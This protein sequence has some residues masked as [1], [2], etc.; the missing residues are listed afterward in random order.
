MIAT[1]LRAEEGGLDTG[2]LMALLVVLMAACILTGWLFSL[3]KSGRLPSGGGRGM[4][5]QWVERAKTPKLFVALFIFYCL[6][7]TTMLSG[8]VYVILHP[9]HPA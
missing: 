4:P 1:F 5:L 6:L 8:L 7:I 9:N 3:Y 2:R